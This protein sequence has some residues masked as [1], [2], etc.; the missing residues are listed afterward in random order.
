MPYG[1]SHGFHNF[2]NPLNGIFIRDESMGTT[3]NGLYIQV[4]TCN[5]ILGFTMNINDISPLTIYI[6]DIINET[7][8]V[9]FNI[10]DTMT[11]G[12]FYMSQCLSIFNVLSYITVVCECLPWLL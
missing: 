9:L 10:M 3:V 5:L 4:I 6:M 11:K 2:K 1:E 7:H 12:R 8:D